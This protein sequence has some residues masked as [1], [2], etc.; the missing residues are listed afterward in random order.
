MCILLSKFS[1][2][3]FHTC[4]MIIYAEKDYEKQLKNNTIHLRAFTKLINH[5]YRQAKKM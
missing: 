5:I 2:V 4:K 1:Y 3:P